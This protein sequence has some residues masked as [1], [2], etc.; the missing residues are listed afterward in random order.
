MYETW[1]LKVVNDLI[2]NWC[3][4]GVFSQV[5]STAC[6]ETLLLLDIERSTK[7]DDEGL[8]FML[9]LQQLRSLDIFHTSLSVEAKAEILKTLRKLEL[10]PRGDF[11]CEA[12]DHL[13][14][15]E[16]SFVSRLDCLDQCSVVG[17]TKTSQFPPAINWR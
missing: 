5:L 7:V 10:L 11:L 12:L 14:E 8:E 16:P 6:R 9:R 1:K 2:I 17:N 13:Q 4:G 15:T 3:D